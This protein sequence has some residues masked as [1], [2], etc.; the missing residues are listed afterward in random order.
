MNS[1]NTSV[2]SSVFKQLLFGY[3]F[4]YSSPSDQRVLTFQFDLSDNFLFLV[5][6][7]TYA[8]QF[9][10][11]VLFQKL[12]DNQLHLQMLAWETENKLC[13]MLNST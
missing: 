3:D 2:L 7:L 4:K 8:L 1:R 12:K 6:V 5:F 13:V 9:C 11:I 10:P